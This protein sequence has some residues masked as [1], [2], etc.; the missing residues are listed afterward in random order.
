MIHSNEKTALMFAKVMNLTFKHLFLIRKLDQVSR[1]IV[2]K[3]AE[4]Q[5]KLGG[6]VKICYYKT[7]DVGPEFQQFK[8]SSD[9]NML[10][11]PV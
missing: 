8:E 1:Q 3:T 6:V 4:I 9:L 11:C 7:H 10:P 5:P 2:Y